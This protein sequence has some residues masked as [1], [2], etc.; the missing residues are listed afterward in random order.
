MEVGKAIEAIHKE[1]STARALEADIAPSL[2]LFE[3]SYEGLTSAGPGWR[4]PWEPEAFAGAP[5]VQNPRAFD[6]NLHIGGYQAIEQISPE[7]EYQS[8][9]QTT[10]E[11]LLPKLT[12]RMKLEESYASSLRKGDKL[13]AKEIE[14]SIEKVD[15]E[16]YKLGATAW[17]ERKGIPETWLDSLRAYKEPEQI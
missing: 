1:C 15:D 17:I 3:S 12:Y 8:L 5:E 6:I 16:I 2:K 13:G 10:K 11:L 7:G 9:G 14:R 4:P